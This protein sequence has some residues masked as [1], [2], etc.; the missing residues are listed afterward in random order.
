MG[1]VVPGSS[2]FAYV[3]LGNEGE[4]PGTFNFR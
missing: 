4:R 3:K 2:V 1:V